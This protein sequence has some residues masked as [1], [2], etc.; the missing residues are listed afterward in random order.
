VSVLG[1]ACPHCRGPLDWDGGCNRCHGCTTGRKE[2][3]TFPGDKYE[4][5]KGHWQRV[6]GPRRACTPE[7]NAAGFAKLY[8]VLGVHLWPSRATR[9]GL[10]AIDPAIRAAVEPIRATVIQPPR[11]AL[12]EPEESM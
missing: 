9:L 11:K 4:L 12:P 5:Q 10:P 8:D 3:W 7:E 2:D 1:V 6:E